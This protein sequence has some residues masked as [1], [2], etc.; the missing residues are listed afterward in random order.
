MVKMK[1]MIKINNDIKFKM[2]MFFRFFLSI[3]NFV[4]LILLIKSNK[5][6][7]IY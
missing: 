1:Y 5:M 3:L 7:N 2:F 6:I 4:I